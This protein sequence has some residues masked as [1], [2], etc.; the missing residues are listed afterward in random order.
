[1]RLLVAEPWKCAQLIDV[2]LRN[3][4]THGSILH[5]ASLTSFALTMHVYLDEGGY[6]LQYGHRIYSLGKANITSFYWLVLTN[7]DLSL[8]RQ[9]SFVEAV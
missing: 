9:T 7:V 1:M 2:A 6:C 3:G 8:Y 4:A 5:E